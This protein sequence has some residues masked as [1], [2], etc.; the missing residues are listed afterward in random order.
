M[1][2]PEA[3]DPEVR[4]ALM[5]TWVT[6]D[7]TDVPCRQKEPNEEFFKMSRENET[8]PDESFAAAPLPTERK[9]KVYAEYVYIGKNLRHPRFE[10]V[11]TA[12]EADVLWLTKSY[13]HF[14]GPIQ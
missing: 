4:R 1:E 5:N 13:K 9:I 8:Y 6:E 3:T 2:G 11:E 7:M 10:M 12:E 14:R